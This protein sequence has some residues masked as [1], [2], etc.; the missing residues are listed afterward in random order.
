MACSGSSGRLFTINSHSISLIRS[1]IGFLL[2]CILPKCLY[3]S[4]LTLL[5]IC[6]FSLCNG[7]I[8]PNPI[9][10]KLKQNSLTICHW[11]LNSLSAHNFAKLTQ[12]KTY[13]SIYKYDFICLSETYLDS[14]TPKSLLEIEGY[15]LVRADHLN[16][17]KKGGIWIYCKK[18]FPLRAINCF[19]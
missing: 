11:N 3:I 2:I 5:Y 9:P 12:L 19:R 15:N 7:D 8:E 17:V 10:R 14:A 16:N 6:S 13:N 4:L 1:F 18:S